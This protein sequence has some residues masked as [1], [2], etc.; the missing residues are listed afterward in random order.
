MGT[1]TERKATPVGFLEVPWRRKAASLFVLV[2]VVGTGDAVGVGSVREERE[3]VGLSRPLGDGVDGGHRSD[4]AAPPA[5]LISLQ[6]LQEH[7]FNELAGALH[8]DFGTDVA[9]SFFSEEKTDEGSLS[10]AAASTQLRGH[11]AAVAEARKVMATKSC[12]KDI[13]VHCGEQAQAASNTP[14]FYESNQVVTGFIT[15]CKT[16]VQISAQAVKST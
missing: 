2:L 12:R 1:L 8:D 14:Q 16:I 5:G 4:R 9:Q 13:R 6:E 3:R 10:L 11:S 7:L 15:V